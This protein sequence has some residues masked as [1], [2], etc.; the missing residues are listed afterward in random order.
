MRAL[1]LFVTMCAA[2]V[3]LD[4]ARAAQPKQL[5]LGG[6]YRVA[7]GAARFSDDQQVL[8]KQGVKKWPDQEKFIP[9]AMKNLKLAKV[10]GKKDADVVL[11]AIANPKVTAPM[12]VPVSWLLD[13]AVNAP[14]YKEAVP[15][16]KAADAEFE[17]RAKAAETA[18][19]AALPVVNSALADLAQ[20]NIPA[21][22]RAAFDKLPRERQFE[23]LSSVITLKEAGKRSALEKQ[24]LTQLPLHQLFTELT[25]GKSAT[26]AVLKFAES[27][28]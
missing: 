21:G 3:A 10:A 2:A 12:N 5:N 6:S 28:Q 4:R 16:L 23:K 25:R 24:F 27:K 14:S 9:D 19:K 15:Y 17:R 20:A 1:V 13:A 22:E 18:G 11:A 7:L 26:G 8:T